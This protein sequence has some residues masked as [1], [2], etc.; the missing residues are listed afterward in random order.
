MLRAEPD[1]MLL[2]LTKLLQGFGNP[3]IDLTAFQE[4]IGTAAALLK[5]LSHLTESL[6]RLVRQAF[7][8][9]QL[10]QPYGGRGLSV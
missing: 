2:E 5:E 9:F 3:V 7:I 1:H 10:Q 4:E 6:Y 8:H